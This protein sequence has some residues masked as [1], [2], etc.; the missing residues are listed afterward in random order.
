MAVYRE[1]PKCKECGQ[2]TAKAIYKSTETVFVGDAFLRWEQI[3]CNCGK[4]SPQS[5]PTEVIAW[6]M[7]NAAGELLYHTIG[8]SEGDTIQ[9]FSNNLVIY[10]VTQ[11]IQEKGYKIVPIKIIRI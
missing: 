4:L 6:C 3:P 8:Q 9:R 2:P 10:T 1:A 11:M 5:E 7:V